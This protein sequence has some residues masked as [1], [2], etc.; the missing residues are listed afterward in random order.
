MKNGLFVVYLND[1]NN[2]NKNKIKNIS[3]LAV[4]NRKF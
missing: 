2:N 3:T 1:D 4:E